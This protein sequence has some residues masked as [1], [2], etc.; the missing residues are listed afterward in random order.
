MLSLFKKKEF[1]TE[2]EK[3]H[4]VSAIQSA[5]KQTSGEVRVFVESRCKYVDPMDRATEIFH[6][7]QMEKTKDSN[8]VLVYVATKDRQLAVL[9]DV[10][11]HKKVGEVFWKETV[12]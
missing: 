9:G 7:L 4:I 1:F 12:N 10:G 11:I 3:T 6:S 8:A 2:T 5:E